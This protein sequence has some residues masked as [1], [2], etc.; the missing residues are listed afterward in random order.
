MV[1]KGGAKLTA[2][3][4]E[5]LDIIQ[6]DPEISYREVAQRLKINDSAAQ[7]HFD[8]LKKKGVLKRVGPAK[9]GYWE[10]LVDM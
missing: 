9:G 5:V 8:N 7:K 6:S 1:Q 10:V 2:K 3:Q 4:Q